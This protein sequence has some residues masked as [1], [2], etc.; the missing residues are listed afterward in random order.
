MIQQREWRKTIGK[1]LPVFD[2]KL[3]EWPE[4]LNRVRFST[5]KCGFDQEE[6]MSRL[7]NT[8]KGKAR[9][10]VKDLMLLC[11]DPEEVLQSLQRKFGR[12]DLIIKKLLEKARGLQPIKDG[13]LESL[14]GLAD[15]IRHFVVIVESL[16]KSSYLTNTIIMDKFVSKLSEGYRLQWA[17]HLDGKA[18]DEASLKHFSS[19]LS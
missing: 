11:K 3:E 1:D 6:N 10:V 17:T 18:M 14:L 8:L 5:T 15:A 9:D 7:R 19:W 4:Y 2:G 12:P 13:E 16:E